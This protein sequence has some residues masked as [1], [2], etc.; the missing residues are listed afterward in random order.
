[1]S[2][3]ER[4]TAPTRLTQRQGGGPSRLVAAAVLLLI[5]VS[6]F[7]SSCSGD[8]KAESDKKKAE[9]KTE[10]SVP[11]PGTPENPITYAYRVT[12][13]PGTNVTVVSTLAG[14]GISPEPIQQVWTVSEKPVSM[15]FP[16]S[17]TSGTVTLKVDSGT[18]ATLELVKGHAVNP[19]DSTAG[20][21]VVESLQTITAN[22]DIAGELSFGDP[23]SEAAPT[24][25]D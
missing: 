13:E 1:M 15:L 4:K 8:K 25:A 6:L 5:G 9:K 14:L 10:K 3:N 17:T 18:N 23:A 2:W 24:T 20:I 11:K 16:A 21:E 19:A 22:V 7:T 12:G